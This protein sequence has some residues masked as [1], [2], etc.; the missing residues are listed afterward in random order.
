LPTC[1]SIS[2]TS[3]RSR[4]DSS[5]RTSRRMCSASVRAC[6]MQHT[7]CTNL[8][9]SYTTAILLHIHSVY[10]HSMQTASAA[11][12]PSTQHARH[13][14]MHTVCVLGKPTLLVLGLLWSIKP[15]L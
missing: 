4:E 14:P 11:T 13:T 1:S 3:L 5:R 8:H 10:F 2:C 15:A 9:T 6:T 7:C 12:H